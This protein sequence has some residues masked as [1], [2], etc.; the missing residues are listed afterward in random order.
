MATSKADVIDLTTCPICLEIL[1][2]PKYLPCLHTFCEKCI[3]AYLTSA[4]EQGKNQSAE[5][6]ICR[7]VIQIH[8]SGLSANEWAN[9]LPDNFLLISLIDSVNLKNAGKVCTSCERMDEKTEAK[10]ACTDC[11]DTLCQNCYRYH[12]HHKIFENHE[13]IPI[14]KFT[15]AFEF[16]VKFQSSCSKHKNEKL[17]LYCSDHVIPCCSVCVSV[18]H[19]KCENVC[20]IEDAALIYHDSNTVKNLQNILT[21]MAGDVNNIL[22]NTS[23]G[24]TTLNSQ[25]K[26]AFQKVESLKEILDQ[27]VKTVTD[28]LKSELTKEFDNETKR[29]EERKT[30]FGNVKKQ[31][32]NEIKVLETCIEKASDVQVMIETGKLKGRLLEHKKH[33][34]VQPFDHYVKVDVN[35]DHSLDESFKK[36]DGACRVTNVVA[37]DTNMQLA[38]RQFSACLKLIKSIAK[39]EKSHYEAC[40]MNN[41]KIIVSCCGEMSLEIFDVKGNKVRTHKLS[42]QPF[43]ITESGPSEVAVLNDGKR[44]S[45][46]HLI[47]ID[48]TDT[49]QTRVIHIK[50]G[51]QSIYFCR[52]KLY[53]A[54]SKTITIYDKSGIAIREIKD[55]IGENTYIHCDYKDVLY[56]SDKS[57]IVKKAE[58][59]QDQFRFTHRDLNGAR[60]ITSDNMSDNIYVTGSDSNNILQISGDGLKHQ[61]LLEEKDG[62]LNPRFIDVSKDGKYLVIT[63]QDGKELLLYEICFDI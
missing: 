36:I 30:I 26:D 1:M 50:S 60:G 53:A 8:E 11:S 42:F 47:K 55:A 22:S 27:K 51:V 45:K 59:G 32:D 62:I 54:D 34:E 10:F 43:D 33:F 4:F 57:S 40:F 41:N 28:R 44:K 24:I 15:S 63:N 21:S 18:E 52:G 13:V 37:P 7:S 9:R 23:D 46:V 5:C 31:L 17:K 14:E 19:R 61:V 3:G 29:L 12:K 38:H 48:S 25:S 16:P 20:T 58:N 49:N 35:I 2:K 6:P 56:V 39:Y